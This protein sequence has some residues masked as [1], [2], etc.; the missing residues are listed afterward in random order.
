MKPEVTCLFLIPF[1]DGCKR[2]AQ[3]GVRRFAWRPRGG[4]AWKQDEAQFDEMSEDAFSILFRR[5]VHRVNHKLRFDQ[6]FFT[7]GSGRSS[8]MKTE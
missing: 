6:C 3:V 5:T 1:D 2:L 4:T 7:G 8:L